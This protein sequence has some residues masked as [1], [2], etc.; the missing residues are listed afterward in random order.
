MQ[1]EYPINPFSACQRR[2][3][4]IKLL[5]IENASFCML[6]IPVSSIPFKQIL[7]VSRITLTNYCRRTRNITRDFCSNV[8]PSFRLPTI[9]W[10]SRFNKKIQRR[11]AK[12]SPNYLDNSISPEFFTFMKILITYRSN[13]HSS[14]CTARRY[15][16][17]EK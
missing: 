16:P 2:T 3:N 7:H 11:Y 9:R 15:Q 17:N 8:F 4:T 1:L 13:L 10:F 14:R 12:N 5:G 6:F